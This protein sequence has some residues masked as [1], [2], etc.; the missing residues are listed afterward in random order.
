MITTIISK[1]L[2]KL[3][4]FN[5]NKKSCNITKIGVAGIKFVQQIRR[6]LEMDCE[7]D[8]SYLWQDK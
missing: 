4:H 7:T 1:E 3:T 2:K 8:L 5:G 6:L